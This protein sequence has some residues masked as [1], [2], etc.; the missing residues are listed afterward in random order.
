M[1]EEL[2][3]LWERYL[4]GR[5][6][7]AKEK[8]LLNYL[9]LVKYIAGRMMVSLP[10][11]VDY[12]DLVSAGAIGLITA[13]ER[14][15]PRHGVKF[16]TYVIPRIKGAILDELRAMDWAPRSLR[17]KARKLEKAMLHLEKKL[18][19]AATDEEIAKEL[20]LKPEEYE[21]LLSEV[22]LASIFSLDKVFQ[23]SNDHKSNLYDM[24]EDSKAE[25][26][27]KVME[28]EEMKRVLMETIKQL[29]EQERLVIAL[30]YYEELTLK[31][32]GHILRVSES[33]VSQ[34]HTK[35]LARMRAKLRELI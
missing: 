16:E 26:P 17:A 23:D 9:P 13:L 2:R 32:I 21:S 22:S 1:T 11:S 18:G 31:E 20:N 14:F 5:E 30:Y 4:N 6:A 34:I 10:K 24:V 8:L 25:D 15:D 12:N 7:E 29:P 27:A 3:S 35:A 33:R 28:K 19:R